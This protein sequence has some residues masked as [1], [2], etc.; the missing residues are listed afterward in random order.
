MPAVGTSGSLGLS[1]RARHMTFS[2]SICS[3]CYRLLIVACAI[4]GT[5]AFGQQAVCE[6]NRYGSL[7]QAL[8]IELVMQSGS[9]EMVEDAILS[10]RATRGQE[11][12]CAELPYQYGG[13]STA[14]PS[15][16]SINDAWSIHS[17]SSAAAGEFYDSCPAIG[18]TAGAYALG[19]WI[20][21]SAG[22]AF[23]S[24]PLIAIAD[25]FVSTQYLA[26]RTPGQMRTWPG[27]FAYARKL[28]DQT[29]DCFVPGVVGAGVEQACSVAPMYCVTYQTG[30]FADR[31]FV[32]GDY[33]PELNI[34]EGGAAFDHGWAGVMMVE[35]ALGATD[36]AKREK[37]RRA[38]LNAG[39]WALD[40]PPVRNHNY[41]AKLVWLLAVLYDWTGEERF[42]DGLID[43]LERN[44]MPGVLMD[45]DNDGTI[46]GLPGQEFADL[47][48]GPAQ[49]PGRYWDAHNALPWYQAMNAWALAEAYAAF[50]SRGDVA[51]MNQLRPFVL[52]TLDNLASELG[53]RGGL[54]AELAGATQVPFAFAIAL[55]KIAD[56]EQLSRP[57]WEDTLWAMWNA[58]LAESPGDNK[59]ATAAIVAARANGARYQSYAKRQAAI[60]GAQLSSARVSGAWFDR[61]RGG[62]GL[63][64]LT[65][66]PDRLLVTWYTYDPLDDDRQVWLIADGDFDGTTFTGDALVTRGTLFGDLFDPGN[67]ELIPW[68]VLSIAFASCSEAQLAW[69]SNLPFFGSGTRDLIKLANIT[70]LE[71]TTDRQSEDSVNS[72]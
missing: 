15:L 12:G 60:D 64:L 42:R 68:G 58:G 28:S 72:G 43:K 13:H 70:G 2:K 34:R 50:R 59:T 25:N 27:L 14:R 41:T 22:L 5:S 53:P 48:S 55:W 40:E 9:K 66:S 24:T 4:A 56:I 18:R 47:V 46:D 67:V 65:P 29:N 35:A 54:P 37:Y 6:L 1:G 19:G 51:W 16:D 57:D 45:L 23:D 8:E 3:S 26:E 63:F 69:Q 17:D 39:Q 36:P 10:A 44:L 38:A 62:E 33:F 21:R 11:L 32:V 61:S 49:T 52:A 71:C 7:A 30:R 31:Q 20:A